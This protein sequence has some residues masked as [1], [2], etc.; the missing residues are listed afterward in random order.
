MHSRCLHS[1]AIKVVAC[2]ETDDGNERV[3]FRPLDRLLEI[4]EERW[5]GRS[6]D[7]SRLKERAI[8]SSRGKERT[9]SCYLLLIE[10]VG[11]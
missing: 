2:N 3:A 8:G 4:V 11:Y 1:R 5:A 9:P 7:F 10:H 6:I